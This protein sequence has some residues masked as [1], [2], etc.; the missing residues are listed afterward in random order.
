V[1]LDIFVFPLLSQPG[2]ITGDV[3][4]CPG[5]HTQFSIQPIPGAEN[6][7]W[8]L[9]VGWTGASTLD[10]IMAVVGTGGTGDIT[11]RANNRCGSSS[12][13][14]LAVSI[15]A[16]IAMPGAIQGKDTIC[17][18]SE[19]R[20]T[21]DPVQDALS[22]IWEF[23]VS[24]NGNST[25]DSLMVMADNNSG[26]S[27]ILVRSVGLCDTSDP[28]RLEIFV[29]QPPSATVMYNS[30]VLTANFD[31]SYTYQ[32]YKDG[33]AEPSGT[34]REHT[35]EDSG[36]YYVL[37]TDLYGCTDTAGYLVDGLV[38]DPGEEDPVNVFVIDATGGG[39][40]YPN[41]ASHAIS[42]ESS[43]TL[44]ISHIR[45]FNLAGHLIREAEMAPE[46]ELDGIP[47]GVYIV[48]AYDYRGYKV[49][50]ARF[51]KTQTVW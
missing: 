40:V 8:S 37:V 45:I 23:P 50:M 28:Q 36:Y 51:V 6:Y 35:A 11:V 27:L 1:D 4:L 38:K 5:V 18:E 43:P 19:N 25:D 42:I 13:E 17:I 2:A 14:T 3:I 24:W 22:Y 47:D 49:A 12:E 48:Q 20:Y 26:T 41:P 34:G 30:P 21:I 15:V 16:P 29:S 46:I 10:T 7:T 32:W 31:T 39:K 33:V 9:P 44:N